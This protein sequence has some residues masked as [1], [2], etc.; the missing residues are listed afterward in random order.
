MEQQV[1]PTKPDNDHRQAALYAAGQPLVTAP[2][3]DTARISAWDE[4]VARRKK[5]AAK[6]AELQ[7]PERARLEADRQA[8]KNRRNAV[9][10]ARKTNRRNKR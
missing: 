7:A 6:I 10:A 4:R 9:Q 2:I 8:E 1:I 5:I 3:A